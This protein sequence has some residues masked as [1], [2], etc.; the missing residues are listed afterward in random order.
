MT[1]SS[2]V[3]IDHIA[4]R[5]LDFEATVAFYR[6]VLGFAVV[7]RWTA[8]GVVGRSAF[9]DS[10]NGICIELFDAQ[11]TV[12]GGPVGPDPAAPA[13]ADAERAAHNA[14]LHLALRTDDV[15]QAYERA[16]AHGARP[17][18]AP[19]DLQQTGLDGHSDGTIRMGFVYGLDGEVIEFIR[20]DDF[21]A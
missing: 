4:L 3:G 8:P 21:G 1:T 19:T 11:T 12:P 15:D 6:D 9:L 17:M 10:G 5:A 14:W 7:Y 18:Q 16:L 20:R 13:P 2:H